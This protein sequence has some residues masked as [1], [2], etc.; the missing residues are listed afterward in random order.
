MTNRIRIFLSA[1]TRRHSQ[2]VLSALG[3]TRTAY[4]TATHSKP[5]MELTRPSQRG[6]KESCSFATPVPLSASNGSKAEVAPATNTMPNTSA[7]AAIKLRTEL[8][9]AHDHRKLNALMAY[10]PKVWYSLLQE[11]GIYEEYAYIVSGLCHG[12]VIGL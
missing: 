3:I 1:Q 12:F 5:G 10:H 11:A 8:K 7:P 9:G 4:S 6:S 2:F